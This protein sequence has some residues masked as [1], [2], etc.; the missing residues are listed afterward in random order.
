MIY[1]HHLAPAY[2]IML[3]KCRSGAGWDQ[4]VSVRVRMR[5]PV[6]WRLCGV[7]AGEASSLATGSA[8]EPGHLGL[9]HSPRTP[10]LEQENI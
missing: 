7:W 5:G 3:Q 4:Q 10:G 9:S 1:N 6:I 8:V 2:V